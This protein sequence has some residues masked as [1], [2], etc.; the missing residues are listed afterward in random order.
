MSFID[1]R[2]RLERPT[3]R[4][5]S[6]SAASSIKATKHRHTVT[7]CRT[8]QRRAT[9]R[10]IK[11]DKHAM[12]SCADPVPDDHVDNQGE[13]HSSSFIVDDV[14]P[15]HSP[16]PPHYPVAATHPFADIKLPIL[17]SGLA[18]PSTR[19]EMGP[20]RMGQSMQIRPEIHR[21]FS[22]LFPNADSRF[23][24]S[25]LIYGVI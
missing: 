12:Q 23:S 13:R 17:K 7:G 24:I 2:R 8:D 9:E 5:C 18:S 22:R 3:A 6:V 11:S 4:N 10:R 15:S 20:A 21:I 1:S 19:N 25:A 16:P 14:Y